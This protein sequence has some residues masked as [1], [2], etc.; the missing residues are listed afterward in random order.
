MNRKT[1]G[2]VLG[3]LLILVGGSGII[4]GVVYAAGR[5]LVPITDSA[6][7]AILAACNPDNYTPGLD[8]FMRATTDYTNLV[9]SAPLLSWMIAYG[10]YRLLP[11]YKSIFT[12]LLVVETVAMAA[13]AAAGKIW[14]NKT[15]AGA[16]VLLV[17]FMLVFFGLAAYLFH[18]M[19]DD[20]MRRFA[21]VFWLILL[22]IAITNTAT[23]YIKKTIA[24]PRPFNDA[25]KPWNEHVRN[26][27]DELLRG[28]NSFP[29]G[30]T[31]G[32]FALLTPIIWYTRNRKVRAGLLGWCVLQG[33]TRV[34]TAAHFP[35]CC[36]MGGVLGF[37]IGTT[38]F[39]ALGGPNLRRPIEP[40]PA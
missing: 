36:L 18:V 33:F 3:R 19:D 20:A 16:N 13:L 30:H 39:F 24:R 17:I 6:D 8:Q 23:D 29:S 5:W 9:I 10:L 32:T 25:N 26:I 21:R 28:K 11:R 38:V 12:G 40:E 2:N 31:S 14:P 15:Y 35:F 37:T 7:K 34:Y 27:P 1:K 22:S 4:V